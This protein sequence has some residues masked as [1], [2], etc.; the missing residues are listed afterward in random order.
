MFVHYMYIYD[1]FSSIKPYL[2]FRKFLEL[3]KKGKFLNYRS[4]KFYQEIESFLLR[5]ILQIFRAKLSISLR[6]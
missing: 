1:F 4:D 5:Y 3:I 6:E 2:W